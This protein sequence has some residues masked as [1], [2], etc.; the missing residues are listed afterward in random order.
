[1]SQAI[2]DPAELRRFAHNL[3]QFNEEMQQ[4]L[5]TLH[6]TEVVYLAKLY[7]HRPV[8]SPSRIGGRLPAHCTASGK[9]FLA[10]GPP[11]Y[12]RQVVEAGLARAVL[13]VGGGGAELVQSCRRQRAAQEP[14]LKLV[15]R[16]ECQSP[17]FDRMPAPL[18]AV[19]ADVR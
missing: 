16:V 14:D 6:G 3:K 9:V 7:G 18:D 8:P 13:E 17:P 1:M 12:L 11:A 5:A 15:E 19:L 4:Q 10:L 2:V